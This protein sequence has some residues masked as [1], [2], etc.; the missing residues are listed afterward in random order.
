MQDELINNLGFLVQKIFEFIFYIL[1][2]FKDL[3]KL[4]IEIEI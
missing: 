4:N 2:K 1:N 3:F